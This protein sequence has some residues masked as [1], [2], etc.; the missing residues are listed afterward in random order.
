[1][2]RHAGARRLDAFGSVVRADFDPL[3]SDLDFLVEFDNAP[4]ATYA[5]A[6]F[7]LKAGLESLFGRPVDLIT[8]RSLANP[9]F[10]QRVTAERQLVYAS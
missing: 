5:Q 7:E 10:R 9:Y 4:P 8:E 2:C 6:Y 1:L 3:R